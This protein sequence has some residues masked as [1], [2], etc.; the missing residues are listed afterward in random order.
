MGTINLKKG[1]KI[2]LSKGLTHAMVGLGWTANSFDGADFDL[3]ASVFLLNDKDK[4]QSDEDLVFYNNP[5]HSS[6]AVRHGGDDRVG[7][8]GSSD[9]EQIFIDFD[10]IPSYVSKLEIVVTI[11]EWKT[12]KQNFGQV[13]RA[14]LRL[15]STNGE[16]VVDGN[17]ELRFD[18]S[19]DYS[20]NTSILMATLYRQGRIWKF[21]SR[22]VGYNE[23]L[24]AFIKRYG[25]SY[26]NGD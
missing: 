14:Y 7:G 21:T 6:G 23:G 11:Y 26:Q 19:E 10:K 15:V 17:E 24:G 1:G 3:D 12:R 2:E 18:L 22:G 13:E 8:D 20:T 16:N 4:M 9:D 5:E 25:N